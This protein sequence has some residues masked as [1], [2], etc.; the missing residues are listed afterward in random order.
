MKKLIL[1]IPLI[2]WLISSCTEIMDMDLNDE[3]NNRL[4]V[5][6][7]ITDELKLHKVKLSR[8]SDYFLNQP[9]K[10]ELG[11]IVTISNE[12][13]LF[14]LVDIDNDGVYHTDK[15]LAGTPGKSYLLNVILAD[16]NVHTAE[17]F[18]KPVPPMD[19]IKYEYLKSDIPFD[20][21]FYYSIN[22]FVQ[23]PPSTGD[24]YQW[25]LFID[26]VHDSD[27]LRNKNFVTD[28]F[29][30]GVY[31]SNW[32]VYQIKEEK[33]ENDTSVIKLQMLSISKE[34]YNFKL[35]ILFETDFS[36]AGFSGP[37][38]NI[39]SNVSNG[40]VG[41]FSASAVTEDSLLIFKGRN[42]D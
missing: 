25:E 6:G 17:S 33:I 38:A 21:S 35:A 16:G 40:A 8:T 15:E 32:P 42:V 1:F 39:P 37:P 23:E 10:S 24:C 31:I 4:V 30:N 29:V 34:E 11:A 9:A 28:D 26:G 14:N 18:M 36:G 13:T 27:T 2:Y 41:Y 19:S 12:D 5:E 7:T 22:I 20:E 3:N